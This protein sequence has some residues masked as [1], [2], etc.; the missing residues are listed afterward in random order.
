[1][2]TPNDVFSELYSG[3]PEV[4]IEKLLIMYPK[5]TWEIVN[6]DETAYVD[7]NVKN[8]LIGL[9]TGDALIL[10]LFSSECGRF[11][12][13]PEEEYGISASVAE[14]IKKYNN[15]D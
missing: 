12:V 1:M 14:A 6:K 11:I 2:N 13:N 10:D 7:D 4:F 15:F 8:R 9:V 5:L 3:E